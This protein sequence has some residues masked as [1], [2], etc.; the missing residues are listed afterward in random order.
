[1]CQNPP[2][3]LGKFWFENTMREMEGWHSTSPQPFTIPRLEDSGIAA[4]TCA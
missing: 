4:R 1:M 2:D 3:K